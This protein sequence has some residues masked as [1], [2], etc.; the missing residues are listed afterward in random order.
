MAE[1]ARFIGT[2]EGSPE[3]WRAS[4][5]LRLQTEFFTL[6]AA[7]LASVRRPLCSRRSPTAN[8]LAPSFEGQKIL[9]RQRQIHSLS[10]AQNPAVAL[11][12]PDEPLSV[13]LNVDERTLAPVA[14]RHFCYCFRHEGEPTPQA[15]IWREHKRS[16]RILHLA[17]STPL[18]TPVMSPVFELGFV[19]SQLPTLVDQPPEGEDWIHEIK[20]DGYRTMLVRDSDGIRAFTRNGFDWTDR[21]PVHRASRCEAELSLCHSRCQVIV[22]DERGVSDFE[23]LGSAIRHE[24]QRLFFFAFD[25]LHLNGS[26]LRNKPLL[27]RRGS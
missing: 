20:H 17:K 3:G 7:L 18:I 26:D 5:R 19:E 9:L 13:V 27:E 16:C 2:I 10:S 23:A 25:L 8:V 11:Q 1:G 15:H 6:G 4:F 12:T 24:P 21:Y 14:D 22:Q